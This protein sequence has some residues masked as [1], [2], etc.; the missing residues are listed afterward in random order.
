MP[1]HQH[2]ETYEKLEVCS[3]T[4]FSLLDLPYYHFYSMEAFP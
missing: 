3:Y 2:Y 4:L 1:N